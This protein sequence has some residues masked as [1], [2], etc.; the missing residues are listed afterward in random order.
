MEKNVKKN[1]YTT[2]TRRRIRNGSIELFIADSIYSGATSVRARCGAASD[3]GYR[4]E[5]CDSRRCAREQFWKSTGN[6]R[7]LSF[8]KGVQMAYTNT[9]RTSYKNIS[10]RTCRIYNNKNTF[11]FSSTIRIRVER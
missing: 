1:K 11:G 6:R 8:S 2:R 5:Y 3:G 9:S 7:N 4:E 10:P